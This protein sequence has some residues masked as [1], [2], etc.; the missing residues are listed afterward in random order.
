MTE[1]QLEAIRAEYA[2]DRLSR[3]IDDGA[4]H[5]TFLPPKKKEGGSEDNSL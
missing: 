1:E 3:Y 5:V 2:S 4:D